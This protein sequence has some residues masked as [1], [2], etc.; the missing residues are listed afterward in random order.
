MY[1]AGYTQTRAYL[2]NKGSMNLYEQFNS[3]GDKEYFFIYLCIPE[4][5]YREHMTM[6]TLRLL[7]RW[8]HCVMS[9]SGEQQG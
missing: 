9:S 1:P 4:R 2:I 3:Y 8:L 7:Q 5:S 6:E